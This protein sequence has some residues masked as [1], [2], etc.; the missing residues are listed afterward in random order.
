M[1]AKKRA[2]SLK[3]HNELGLELEKMR[4]RLLTIATDLEKAYPKTVASLA[5]RSSKQIDKLRCELD[6]NVCKENPDY[7]NAIRVY[8][9]GRRP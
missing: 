3:Q 2:F 5:A 6:N 9:R 1:S 8:Y 4:D 7:K